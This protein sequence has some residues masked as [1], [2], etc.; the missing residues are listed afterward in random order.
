MPI[1][2]FAF[3]FFSLIW[4]VNFN[5]SSR[6]TLKYFWKELQTTGILLKVAGGWTPFWVL[7]KNIISQA[8]LDLSGLKA[9][10][11]W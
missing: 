3:E 6:Y 10:F 9:I 7:R 11:H 4:L 5:F 2:L 8:R 1:P